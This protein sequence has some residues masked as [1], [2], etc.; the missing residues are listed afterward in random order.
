MNDDRPLVYWEVHKAAI[1]SA[2]FAPGGVMG[3]AA[4]D[5]GAGIRGIVQDT[6]DD[7]F[8]F[9][10]VRCAVRGLRYAVYQGV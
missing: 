2:R 3:G 6:Q 10:F 8:R 4:I 5:I 1:D 7:R 9:Y